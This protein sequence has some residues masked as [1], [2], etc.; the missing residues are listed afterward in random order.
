MQSFY[1]E[2]VTSWA[3]VL[4]AL[5]YFGFM[6]RRCRMTLFL[7]NRTCA[8]PTFE[9]CIAEHIRFSVTFLYF[10][11]LPWCDSVPFPIRISVAFARESTRECT[12]S[13]DT[14]QTACVLVALGPRYAG[15]LELESLVLELQ[16]DL[17]GLKSFLISRVDDELMPPESFVH[18]EEK[19]TSFWTYF[20]VELLH[21]PFLLTLFCATSPYFRH[22]F[23]G[24]FTSWTHRPQA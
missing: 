12:G 21:K 1:V 6:H 15:A 20:S 16:N 9:Y 22:S 17:T 10:L 24:M 5:L 23:S 19:M 13:Q 8:T 3:F 7:F 4:K 18:S 2:R 14:N 11:S